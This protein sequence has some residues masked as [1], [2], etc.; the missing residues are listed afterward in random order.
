MGKLELQNSFAER[1][2]FPLMAYRGSDSAC[3]KDVSIDDYMQKM[4]FKNENGNP[5]TMEDLYKEIG[6]TPETLNLGNILSLSGDMKYL[7][8]EIVRQFINEGITANPW[9]TDLLSGTETV[10]QMAVVTPWIKILDAELDPTA[11]A[12]T[13][14]KSGMTWGSKT[15]QLQ[16]YAK[17]LDYSDELLL[18]VKLPILSHY[19]REVGMRLSADLNKAAVTTLINGDQANSVDS[20]ATIGVTESGKLD[21]S[22]FLRAWVR[23]SALGKNWFTVVCNEAM[24]NKLLA[25]TEF[26]NPSGAGSVPVTLNLRNRVQPS[27]LPVYVSSAVGDNNILLVDPAMSMLKLDFMPLRVE[28]ER[29]MSRQL[30][31]TYASIITGFSTL[32]RKNRIQLNT[33]SAFSSAGFPSW[34][35]AVD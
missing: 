4:G 32:D 29:I 33:A 22:D 30:G 7:A 2:Y 12:E 18:S 5:L 24:A 13:I 16:K 20:V 26:K 23:G 11:E 27:Q 19:M 34:M 3:G 17:G 10:D 1:I 28:S 25:L 35:A 15:I 21:F 6:Q 31:A 8:P 14:G 9:Y